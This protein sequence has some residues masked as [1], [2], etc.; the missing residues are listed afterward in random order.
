MAN[1]FRDI[2]CNNLKVFK[3]ICH[4]Y[5]KDFYPSIQMM[6][7]YK[8]LNSRHDSDKDSKIVINTKIRNGLYSTFYNDTTLQKFNF[9]NM[10]NFE[11]N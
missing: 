7:F 9:L 8:C 2:N 5:L 3:W 11:I 1:G 4:M 10:C 6:E